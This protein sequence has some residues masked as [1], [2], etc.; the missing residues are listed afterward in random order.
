[1]VKAVTFGKRERV[2][3]LGRATIAD[4]KPIEGAAVYALTYKQDP[5]NR[6]RAHTVV[7]FG[8]TAD[9]ALPEMQN[10]L[11]R[12]WHEN[13]G[14][15]GELFFFYHPMPGSNRYERNLVK[16]KLAAEYQPDGND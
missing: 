14:A 5:L 6:P 7:Y 10:E 1:M 3:F 16:E 2:R 9:L 4:W 11:S 15:K 8:E 12:W 13:S